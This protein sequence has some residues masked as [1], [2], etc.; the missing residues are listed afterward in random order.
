MRKFLLGHAVSR[1]SRR[2]SISVLV[3]S[4]S[5]MLMPTAFVLVP[6]RM[7]GRSAIICVFLWTVGRIGSL[8][9]HFLFVQWLTAVAII[10]SNCNIVLEMQKC[11]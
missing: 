11:L 8:S 3:V 7:V 2:L 6:V 10:V 1:R 5:L 4:V 9:A